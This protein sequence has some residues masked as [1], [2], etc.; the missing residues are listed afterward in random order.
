MLRAACSLDAHFGGVEVLRGVAMGWARQHRQ[1][2]TGKKCRADLAANKT[3]LVGAVS[4]RLL[5]GGFGRGGGETGGGIGSDFNKNNKINN[6]KILKGEVARWNPRGFG[7]IRPTDGGDPTEDVFC[8][9]SSIT[10]GTVLCEGDMVE[11]QAEYNDRK[12]KYRAIRVTGGR[13]EGV[14]GGV[15]KQIDTE[16]HTRAKR[17]S[18]RFNIELN[19]EIMR[20]TDTKEL[21]DFICKHAAE[22]NHVNVATAFRKYA[23]MGTT[24]GERLMG[25]LE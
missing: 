11:Y 12:G 25:Q 20:I 6:R 16:K 15:V 21:C 13:K 5:S 3:V 4:R 17:P 22:F 2:N 14:C 8:H 1:D 23:T 10:D 24:P 19:Q 7:F 9:I 18:K